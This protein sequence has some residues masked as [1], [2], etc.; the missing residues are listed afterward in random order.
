ME[1][2]DGGE[3]REIGWVICRENGSWGGGKKENLEKK[4]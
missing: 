4:L 3:D 1:V 2:G